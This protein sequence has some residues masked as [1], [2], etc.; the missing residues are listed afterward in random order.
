MPFL[1]VKVGMLNIHAGIIGI[2]QDGPELIGNMG[3]SDLNSSVPQFLA[4]TPIQV[5]LYPALFSNGVL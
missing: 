2:N 5:S 3:T 4:L 1:R